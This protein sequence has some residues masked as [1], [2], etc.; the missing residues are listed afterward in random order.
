[1]AT[2]KLS[3]LSGVN[4]VTVTE[5]ANNA[6]DTGNLSAPTVLTGTNIYLPKSAIANENWRGPAMNLSEFNRLERCH[7]VNAPY[8]KLLN[9]SAVVGRAG[10]SGNTIVLG[11]ETSDFDD[12]VIANSAVVGGIAHVIRVVNGVPEVRSSEV[13]S[14]QFDIWPLQAYIY[15][16]SV[17]NLARDRACAT[18]TIRVAFEQWREGVVYYIGIAGVTQEGSIGPISY[19][20]T[21]VITGI[22]ANTKASITHTRVT[23]TGNIQFTTNSLLAPTG[24][25]LTEISA[26]IWEISS[27]A[28]AGAFGYR[29]FVSDVDPATMPTSQRRTFVLANDGGFAM[30][31]DKCQMFLTRKFLIPNQNMI[32]FRT[33]RGTG[34]RGQLLAREWWARDGIIDP[35]INGAVPY[36]WRKFVPGSDPAPETGLDWYMRRGYLAG[37]VGTTDTCGW[38][39]PATDTFYEQGTTTKIYAVEFWYKASA[40]YNFTFVPFG[41]SAFTLN[42]GGGQSTVTS[43]PISATTTWQKAT[44]SIR[45]DSI[46][47]S[48]LGMSW[49]RP[50]TDGVTL[51]IAGFSI[52]P[53]GEV[54]MDM[55]AAAKALIPPNCLL[56][57]HVTVNDRGY[58]TE[59]ITA[60]S[61][62]MVAPT[63]DSFLNLCLDVGATPYMQL[64]FYPAYNMADI[65]AYLAAPVSSGH[66]Y[67]LRRQACGRTAP[68]TDSFTKI[69]IE[70]GNEPWNNLEIGQSSFIGP[71]TMLDQATSATI[72]AAKVYGHFCKMQLDALEASPY[73]SVLEPILD[74]TVCGRLGNVYG[75]DAATIAG[76]SRVSQVLVNTYIGGDTVDFVGRNLDGEGYFTMS[77]DGICSRLPGYQE[78]VD[79]LTPLGI[80]SAVYE[81]GI[82]YAQDSEDTAQEEIDN[83]ILG[84]SRS[85]ISGTLDAALAFASVNGAFFTYF[86]I[87]PG[88]KWAS[89]ALASE[90]GQEYGTWAVLRKLFVE[91]G[92]SRVRTLLN[93]NPLTISVTTTDGSFTPAP[94]G[95]Y[96]LESI[97]YPGR[98][99]IAIC[100]RDI[101]RSLLAPDDPLYNA[102]YDPEHP[103][104]IITGITSATS[105][106][107]LSFCGDF[108]EH[109]RYP[110]GFRLNASNGLY[111][112][113]DS[114]CV[115][116]AP[117][118]QTITPPSFARIDVNTDIE[119]V[120]GGPLII[121]FRGAT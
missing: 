75:S 91:L 45:A 118:W 42:P 27:A 46:P 9:R 70:N 77:S 1:M 61:G 86:D 16:D 52:K 99:C 33:A 3:A 119:P 84:K 55:D 69:I 58:D 92:Q 10:T 14:A 71:R 56:R 95:V 28:V 5:G 62:T 23:L 48:T 111:D 117:D 34:A 11:T 47:T 66:P 41:G 49:G 79:L 78:V 107:K 109:N 36:E 12:N 30:E 116:I 108:R 32:H 65:A 89:R 85:A 113:A 96:V 25:T 29:A 103:V 67:A 2:L 15:A 80:Q 110:V 39:G 64:Q 24:V 6:S 94:F 26:G 81:G 74:F 37:Q 88:K 17:D 22:P 90:G 102:V 100:P 44:F 8:D 35:A 18:S 93:F 59:L 51:M 43:V 73:W 54:A 21:T 76:P 19:L 120:I 57:N 60:K 20:T 97:T 115:T 105:V 82:G 53:I 83:E 40:A 68:W 31:P 13:I 106:R 4:T 114:T 104:E 87:R 98:T 72:T 121:S 112:I 63:I 38:V 50:N 7:L 101:D